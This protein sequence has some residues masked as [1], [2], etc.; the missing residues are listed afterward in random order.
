MTFLGRS[1]LDRDAKRM[2]SR[3]GVGDELPATRAGRNLPGQVKEDLV[4]FRYELL[5]SGNI[6]HEHCRFDICQRFED[7]E[8]FLVVGA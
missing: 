5:R 6:A 3:P 1:G 2:V 4:R 7:V 8:V